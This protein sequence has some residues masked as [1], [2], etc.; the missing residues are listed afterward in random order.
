MRPRWE[1]IEWGFFFSVPV[2]DQSKQTIAKAKSP[3]TCHN[4]RSSRSLLA[5][6]LGSY[7]ADT[8]ENRTWP[9]E[10]DQVFFA[11]T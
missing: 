11:A 9:S 7:R 2:L 6:C 8:L 1:E 5:K 10:E 4:L 3:Y